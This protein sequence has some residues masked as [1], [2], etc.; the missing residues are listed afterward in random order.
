VSISSCG[1]STRPDQSFSIPEQPRPFYYGD[2]GPIYLDLD[3]TRLTMAT[4]LPMPQTALAALQA[5]GVA[6]D[7]VGQTPVTTGHW[8]IHLHATTPRSAAERAA[9]SLR[10][11]EGVT[12]ASNAYYYPPYGTL[13]LVINEMIVRFRAETQTTEIDRLN[14]LCGT[15]VVTHDPHDPQRYILSYPERS[16]VTPL[17]VASFYAEQPAVQYA[18][19]DFVMRIRR[20]PLSSARRGLGMASAPRRPP[21]RT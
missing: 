14:R 17:A 16:G 6:V 2:N 21:G 8:T 20:A 11:T 1:N 19:P 12:F 10:M 3:S 4:S 13:M 9:R 7:S 15:R 18:E 5:I